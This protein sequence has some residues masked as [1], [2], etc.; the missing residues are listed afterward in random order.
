MKKSGMEQRMEMYLQNVELGTENNRLNARIAELEAALEAKH[1]QYTG[2]V[3]QLEEARTHAEQYRQNW[4]ALQKATGEECQDRALEVIRA[5]R[6]AERERDEA[7]AQAQVDADNSAKYG[8]MCLA[9]EAQVVQLRLLGEHCQI[10]AQSPH[11]FL[12][13][14]QVL[15]RTPPQSLALVKAGVYCE[16]AN[17]I[18]AM[19]EHPIVLHVVHIIQTK[20]DLLTAEAD[21]L[22]KEAANGR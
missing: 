12:R 19:S 14:D 4:L 3:I 11:V 8:S 5:G 22:E 21:R 7:Q 9:L 2:A 6:E 1:Q 17:E 20:A 13:N 18:A 16:I 10:C 15:S